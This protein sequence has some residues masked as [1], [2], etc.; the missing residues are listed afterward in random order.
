MW[1]KSLDENSRQGQGNNKEQNPTPFLNK[2]AQPGNKRNPGISL[3]PGKDRDCQKR[4]REQE[5]QEPEMK[6]PVTE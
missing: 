5:T 4:K 2:P 1:I 6:P 3:E